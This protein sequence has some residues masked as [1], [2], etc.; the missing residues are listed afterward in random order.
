[1][2]TALAWC[3]EPHLFIRGRV[4]IYLEDLERLR[5]GGG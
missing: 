3:G 4:L 2:C 1:M 5:S